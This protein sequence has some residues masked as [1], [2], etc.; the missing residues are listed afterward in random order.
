MLLLPEDNLVFYTMDGKGHVR[1]KRSLIGKKWKTHAA[2]AGSRESAARF[3][4]GNQIA[5]TVYKGISPT[6]RNYQLFCIFKT[7]A[8]RLLKE[9]N[10]PR[11]VKLKLQQLT[12]Q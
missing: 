12:L 9:G 1:T 5:C 11:E 7:T 2:F 6:N 3:A 4:V 10:T 8:I